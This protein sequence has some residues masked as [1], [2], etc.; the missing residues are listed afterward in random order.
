[1]KTVF[2][3]VA[4]MTETDS[5]KLFIITNS[6]NATKI[7]LSTGTF[8]AIGDINNDGFTELISG[9]K[10][11]GTIPNSKQNTRPAKMEKPTAVLYADAGKLNVSW[12]PG[13]DAETSSCI[14][15]ES[16]KGDIFLGKSNADGTRRSLEVG[17][18]GRNLKYLLNANCLSEGKYYIAIQAIDAGGLGGPWSDELV[19]E[20][21]LSAPIISNV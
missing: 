7:G 3:V 19:Y 2:S 8:T 1:M 17:N 5:T 20:H 6:S 16:G 21:K 15:S 14:G 13:K 18:M 12:A 4:I 9:Y 10:T 11:V